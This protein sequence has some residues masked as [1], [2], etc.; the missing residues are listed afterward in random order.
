MNNTKNR[1]QKYQRL[2]ELFQ[3]A[4]D[5]RSAT[6]GDQSK[7]TDCRIYLTQEEQDEFLAIAREL[8]TKAQA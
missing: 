8:S 5:R 3:I 4:G 2:R 7:S 6:G 1:Q